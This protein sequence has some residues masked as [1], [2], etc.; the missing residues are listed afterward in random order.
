MADEKVE[1]EPKLKPLTINLDGRPVVFVPIQEAVRLLGISHNSVLRRIKLG[2][3]HSYRDPHNGYRYVAEY[4]VDDVL[5]LREDIA[6]AAALPGGGSFRSDEA[7]EREL[8]A[9]RVG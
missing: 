2:A 8:E 7:V 3:L 5:K 6:K 4:S 9:Q 1:R